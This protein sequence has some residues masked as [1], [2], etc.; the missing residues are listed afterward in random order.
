MCIANS[1][2]NAALILQPRVIILGYSAI[3][4]TLPHHNKLRPIKTPTQIMFSLC[5]SATRWLRYLW[6]TPI[7][8]KRQRIL[9]RISSPKKMRLVGYSIH[10]FLRRITQAEHV[11]TTFL[12]GRFRFVSLYICTKPFDSWQ[13]LCC[14]CDVPAR[15]CRWQAGRPLLWWKHVALYIL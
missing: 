8:H 2:P 11:Y 5:S 3:T 7:I 12:I 6:T 10:Q 14:S 9:F 1:F 15:S 13:S 4:Y